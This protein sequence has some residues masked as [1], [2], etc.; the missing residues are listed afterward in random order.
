MSKRAIRSKIEGTVNSNKKDN[1]EEAKEPIKKHE[2]LEEEAKEPIK[3]HE[4]SNKKNQYAEEFF[5]A[6]RI[7][8]ENLVK[9][10]IEKGA[11]LNSRDQFNCT[12][13]MYSLYFNRLEIT[14]ILLATGKINV[15][16]VNDVNDGGK[17]ALHF[18]CEKG[19][20]DIAKELV[21]KGAA[22]NSKDNVYQ[23][24][25][26]FGG[27]C[28]YTPLMYGIEHKDI[29]EFLIN[30]G[31]KVHTTGT[32]KKAAIHIAC[33]KGNL[34]AVEILVK[35]G[36]N[37][38]MKDKNDCTPLMHA[39]FYNKPEITKFLLSLQKVNVNDIDNKGYTAFHRAC[40]EKSLEVVK[41]LVE[42]KDI[43]LTI[44]DNKGYSA[45]HKIYN[46]EILQ[47]LV[48]NKHFKNLKT[49]DGL[50][51][52]MKAA[53][54][55]P[56]QHHE[57]KEILEI[58]LNS[59]DAINTINQ[60]D[61]EGNTALH[62]IIGN[63]YHKDGVIVAKFL[64]NKA[65]ITIKN[66]E[67]DTPFKVAVEQGELEIVKLFLNPLYK[68]DNNDK[69]DAFHYA[70]GNNDQNL[71]KLFIENGMPIDVK[72]QDGVTPFIKCVNSLSKKVLPILIKNGTDILEKDK[73]G[74][75]ATDLLIKNYV[76]TRDVEKLEKKD[77]YTMDHFKSGYINFLKMLIE[78]GVN[79][80]TQNEQFKTFLS[81]VV[82]YCS[83][84]DII[85]L[86]K[87]EGINLD[88]SCTNA[89]GQTRLH[90]ACKNS[91]KEMVEFLIEK[92]VDITIKDSFGI[93]PIVWAISSSG[94]SSPKIVQILLDQNKLDING[95]YKDFVNVLFQHKDQTLLDHAI[96]RG[97][98]DIVKLLIEKGADI[99]L[100]NEFGEVAI[101]AAATSKSENA[102]DIVEYLTTKI[103]KFNINDLYNGRTLLHY[104]CERGDQTM[105]KLLINELKADLA[106]NDKVGNTALM[107][108]INTFNTRDVKV[109][110]LLKYLFTLPSIRSSIDAKNNNGKTAIHFV[111]DLDKLK[112]LIQE[113]ADIKLKDK[114]GN[115]VIDS[116]LESYS[117]ITEKTGYLVH[118]YSLVINYLLKKGLDVPK[119]TKLFHEFFIDIIN[120]D[121]NIDIKILEE[122]INWGKININHASDAGQTPIHIAC[123]KQNL[124]MIKLLLEKGADPTIKENKGNTALPY[125]K[126]NTAI[127]DLLISKGKFDSNDLI[128]SCNIDKIKT[129]IKEQKLDIHYKDEQTG[130]TA[131]QLL[132]LK[133]DLEIIKILVEKGADFNLKDNKNNTT[134][135]YITSSNNQESAKE[136]AELLIKKGE[137]E[138]NAEN[139]DSNT[140]LHFACIQKFQKIAKLLVQNKSDVNLQNNENKAPID[141]IKEY[142]WGDIEILFIPNNPFENSENK[143]ESTVVGTNDN[144]ET[145]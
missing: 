4:D 131:V 61:N 87:I 142:N 94:L 56:H 54:S 117:N 92:G 2:G 145:K 137:F 118:K 28:G 50:T 67:G 82:M 141:Y 62:F 6:C 134:F 48:D 101:V 21:E 42:A 121:N 99:S 29:V 127:I 115:N 78:K 73:D 60:T 84:E 9:L 8:D 11:D 102:K 17:G 93:I 85:N 114:E 133:G 27:G 124:D 77:Y 91:D 120:L 33:M 110:N 45:F 108:A 75:T 18:A 89:K 83:K 86:S 112:L 105:I 25:T 68:I 144:L 47:F 35:K 72:D 31:A 139:N 128:K 116:I 39:A 76:K 64:E 20:I 80:P 104:A 37:I 138:C 1:V 36:A 130:V 32:K 12:P 103:E 97:N 59:N 58:L 13:L 3:N 100:K 53:K 70:C 135:H 63:Y 125:A 24:T 46:E 52:L 81:D 98:I 57:Y 71:V 19:L 16:D 23:K 41:I 69:I 65:D 43:D 109:G 30:K 111:T 74:N 26:S 96:Q 10:L 113:G 7:G 119:D 106:I 22:L 88:F 107:Y 49:K 122:L 132:C 44:P 123:L 5:Q 38:N 55:Q 14:K 140:P 15:N 129:L 34:E 136:I 40:E 95:L 66:N 51:P 143:S 126:G 79:L 90:L